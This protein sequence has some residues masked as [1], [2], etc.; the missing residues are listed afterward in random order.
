[1]L[2]AGSL[3]H[4]VEGVPVTA[5]AEIPYPSWTAPPASNTWN[6]LPSVRALV[7]TAVPDDTYW[8]RNRDY[9]KPALLAGMPAAAQQVA[10]P[11]QMFQM[12]PSLQAALG[13][14]GVHGGVEGHHLLHGDRSVHKGPKGSEWWR[15][16]V[17]HLTEDGARTLCGRDCTEWLTMDV[18]IED[19]IKSQHLCERCRKRTQEE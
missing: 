7:T 8:G 19:A 9:W 10:E 18:S 15:R 3:P 16:S 17:H 6:A 4:S 1:M 11:T 13:D 5:G 12:L 2:W 14:G